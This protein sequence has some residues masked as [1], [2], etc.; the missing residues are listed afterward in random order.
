[1]ARAGPLFQGSVRLTVAHIAHRGVRA[2]EPVARSTVQTPPAFYARTRLARKP[3]QPYI[4]AMNLD[5]TDEEH[6]ALL[7]LVK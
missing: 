7:R 6:V 5:Q 1:M 4:G 2:E 3:R